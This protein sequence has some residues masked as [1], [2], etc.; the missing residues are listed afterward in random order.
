MSERKVLN[1]YIPPDFDPEK[2]S[3][4]KKILKRIE[5]K[6]NKQNKKNSKNFMNIRM[7]Y[8]FTLRCSKCKSFTYVGTKFNSRVEKVKDEDYLKIPIWKFYGKCSECRNEIVFK[9]DPKNGDYVMVSGGIRTY[10]AHKEQEVADNFY[11][12]NGLVPENDK[13][14]N[15]EKQSYNAMLEL[16]MNEQLEELQNINKRNAD[17]M[18]SI[19]K[20][21][22]HL[23]EKNSIH[24]KNEGFY[25][26]NLDDEDEKA[27]FN[28]LNKSRKSEIPSTTTSHI[29]T[30]NNPKDI[31][32]KKMIVEEKI[33]EE[34]PSD[35]ERAA[36]EKK[37]IKESIQKEIQNN[38]EVNNLKK[39]M[40]LKNNLLLKKKNEMIGYNVVI[41]KKETV[42]PGLFS[43]YNS[44]ESEEEK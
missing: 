8:P 44:S 4:K 11:R 19:N 35:K 42:L 32:E 20:A 29:I 40:D 24:E 5:K 7:M 36:E 14:K 43:E 23:Y 17:K 33:V 27:F 10:D 21:L 28:L 16:K 38:T 34:L 18:Y 37:E 2:L 3:Q 1:K 41:K 13:V 26:N 9:T 12:E 25:M 31:L 22:T 6:K 30:H 39:K 15:T